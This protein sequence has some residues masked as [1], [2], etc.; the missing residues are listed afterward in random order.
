MIIVTLIGV[1]SM[2]A[3]PSFTKFIADNR[4]QSLNN[5]ILSLLQFARS[6]AVE[7]RTLVRVCQGESEWTVK[8]EC[9]DSSETLRS[10]SLPN[11]ASISSSRNELT[12]RYNGT[13]SEAVLM[14]CSDDQ[15]ANGYTIDVKSSGSIRTWARGKNGPG[16]NDEM[17]T[18]TYQQPQGGDDETQG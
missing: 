2:I 8:V 15:A 9:L 3:V 4:T 16:N 17:T 6:T 5:E 11:G 12:F 13:G 7:R 1:F 10:V 14:T 18:C